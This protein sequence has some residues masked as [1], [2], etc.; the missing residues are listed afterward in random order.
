MPAHHRNIE[1]SFES[2]ELNAALW[3]KVRNVL[4]AVAILGWLASAAA[5]ASGAAHSPPSS[6]G[7]RSRSARCSSSWCST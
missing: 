1:A 3:S 2:Y 4:A 5:F 6:S 7:S